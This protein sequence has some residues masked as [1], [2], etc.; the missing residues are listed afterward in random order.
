[1]VETIR[2][3]LGK[4]EKYFRAHGIV[5]TPRLD[6]EVLLA[7]V[8]DTDR[9]GLYVNYDKPLSSMELGMYREVVRKRARR[10]PVA[11]IIGKKDFMSGQ[12]QVNQSVLIPR[13]E[14]ELLLEETYKYLKELDVTPERC[15]DLG[16]GSG[17][18]AIELA[19]KYEALHVYAV[20]ISGEAL[21][22]A[23]LNA[24][25][26]GVLDRI[27]FV[28]GD[29]FAP[30]AGMVEPESVE[31]L[32]SNP[33][34]I[35][36]RDLDRLQPEVSRFEPRVALD[37][38]EDGLGFYRRIASD[39]KGFLKPLGVV[40][41]EVGAGQAEAVVAILRELGYANVVV[42]KDYSDIKRVV[43]GHK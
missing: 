43:I 9:V 17:I 25:E 26:H 1:M 11:Y 13:P 5:D 3:V 12:Y 35:A 37:G 16:T 33:P 30:L 34:Y 6:A 19:K 28:C 15:V 23:R 29:L 7:D 21:D 38:G 20:D 31:L 18:L 24:K 32:I 39:G 10:M 42:S 40:A 2:S 4:T 36:T 14:T 8:L 22:V 27:T 41:F